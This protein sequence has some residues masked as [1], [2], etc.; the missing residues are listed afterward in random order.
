MIMQTLEAPLA[1]T[2]SRQLLFKQQKYWG[3]YRQDLSAGLTFF[4]RR[5]Y[6]ISERFPRAV[7][8][9]AHLLKSFRDCPVGTCLI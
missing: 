1:V 2:I 5:R 7:I 8:R 3:K 9:T 6:H 4:A